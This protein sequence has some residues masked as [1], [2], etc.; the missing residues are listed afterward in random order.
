MNIGILLTDHVGVK[1][2]GS[3]TR[4]TERPFTYFDKFTFSGGKPECNSRFDGILSPTLIAST[5]FDAKATTSAKKERYCFMVTMYDDNCDTKGI[6]AFPKNHIIIGIFR[7]TTR[8]VVKSCH[9]A[10][11][12]L[13]SSTRKGR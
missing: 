13:Q 7:M 10:M 11:L 9:V 12:A 1:A 4:M 2:P 6:T 5:T 3:P 8:V